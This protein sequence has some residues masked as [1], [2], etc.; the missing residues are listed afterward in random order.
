[1]PPSSAVHDDCQVHKPGEGSADGDIGFLSAGLPRAPGSH[2]NRAAPRTP[3]GE[4]MRPQKDDAWGLA[5]ATS[6]TS[7]KE[8]VNWAVCDHV[9]TS[10]AVFCADGALPADGGAPAGSACR[11]PDAVGRW[12]A[13][14]VQGLGRVQ[15]E[16]HAAVGSQVI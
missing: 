2:R 13:P 1:M 14:V 15:E 3:H 12:N 8:D 4:D 16:A 5:T 11:F 7:C 6:V 10:V 9:A